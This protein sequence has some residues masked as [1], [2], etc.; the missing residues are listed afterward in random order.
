MSFMMAAD[1]QAAR[2]EKAA[3]CFSDFYPGIIFSSFSSQEYRSGLTLPSGDLPDPGAE[4]R[5]L[6]LQVDSLPS[7]PPG[8]PFS[9][10][11]TPLL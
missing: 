3:Y 11:E 8:N 5:S 2:E 9:S 6:A 1:L 7:E 4:P 10:L